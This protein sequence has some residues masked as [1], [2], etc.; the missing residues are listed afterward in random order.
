MTLPSQS[1]LGEL[2]YLD[3]NSTLNTAFTAASTFVGSAT[4]LRYHELDF[5]GLVQASLKGRGVQTRA[6]GHPA[7]VAGKKEGSFSF[8]MD[9]EGGSADTSAG[10][11]ATLLGA[12]LGGLRNPTAA[13]DAAEASS[14]A[15]Q[16]KAT[17]HGMEENELVLVGTAADSGGDGRVG[18][19]EDAATSADYYDLQMALPAA[20]STDDV[21]KNGHTLYIDWDDES[22]QDFLFIGDHAGTS[23]T[24]DPDSWQALGCSLSE[25]AFG[26]FED[27][28]PWVQ[29]T[30]MVSHFQFVN[31][32]DQATFAHA[33]AAN[34]GDP[35]GGAE[36]GQLLIQDAGT[37]TRN[38]IASG[39][40]EIT[41]ALNL[42][43]INNYNNPNA[44]GGF[45]K[46]RAETGPTMTIPAYWAEIAD[47]PGLLNDA[48]AGTAKQVLYQCGNTTQGTVAFYG[49]RGF[50]KP[51]GPDAMG[52][53]EELRTLNLE[54]EFDSGQATDES[55]DAKK[56]EDAGLVIGFM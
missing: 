32:A 24:N 13:S 40:V 47:M 55:T 21:I 20:P 26:G 29:F 37:T 48:N 49:Q 45:K 39:N 7:P 36:H 41:M 1:G 43:K 52:D 50:V 53:L 44:A 9:L 42:K 25:V 18:A 11:V 10:T 14:T 16:I 5:S 6:G 8:K 35:V 19:I 2:W 4:K 30:Y 3:R 54:I 12:G 56:L 28:H 17:G 15:T 22:Y 38:A 33:T 27:G 34:G 23:G 31:Y 46:C 51:F